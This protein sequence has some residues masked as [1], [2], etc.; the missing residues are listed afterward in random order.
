MLLPSFYNSAVW[1]PVGGIR[2]LKLEEM[3]IMD[4][5]TLLY[6]I[7]LGLGL[8]LS[9]WFMDGDYILLGYTTNKFYDLQGRFIVY[10]LAI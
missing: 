4:C 1:P 6:Y 10:I 8:C 7:A 2:K 3:F 9:S 5:P